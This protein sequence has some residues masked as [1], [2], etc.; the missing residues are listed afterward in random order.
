MEKDLPAF[1]AH[2]VCKL[3]MSHHLIEFLYNKLRFFYDL[4]QNI[5]IRARYPNLADMEKDL[6]A[7]IA[8]RVRKLQT[9]RHLI[10]EMDSQSPPPPRP[11]VGKLKS[12]AVRCI[13]P[14]IP[15]SLQIVYYTLLSICLRDQIWVHAC[16]F[17][18]VNAIL[19][20]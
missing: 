14:G 1:I 13:S 10:E 2:R 5:D 11:P 16:I 3:Q 7:F 4:F 6:P 19:G 9:S 20:L 8:H 15:V 12:G 18:C 17:M